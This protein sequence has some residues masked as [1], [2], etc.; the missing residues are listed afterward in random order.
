[1]LLSTCYC[2]LLK[3][4]LQKKTTHNVVHNLAQTIFAD[5]PESYVNSIPF[6]PSTIEIRSSNRAQCIALA[7][8]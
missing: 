7:V 2:G 5:L 6:D 3:G 1:M 8:V 4:A